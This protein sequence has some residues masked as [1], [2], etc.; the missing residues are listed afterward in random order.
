MV[1]K[2]PHLASRS[3]ISTSREIQQ[4]SSIQGERLTCPVPDDTLSEF[5]PSVLDH[6][7]EVVESLVALSTDNSTE[8]PQT[9]A[10]KLYKFQQA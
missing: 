10:E 5:E 1:A 6:V 7:R 4:R 8:E 3:T 9:P 2:R